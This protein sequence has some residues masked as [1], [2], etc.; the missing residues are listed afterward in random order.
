MTATAAFGTASIEAQLRASLAESPPR[1]RRPRKG[2]GSAFGDPP[3]KVPL[4]TAFR[5]RASRGRGH[6]AKGGSRGVR[7]EIS[8][9]GAVSLPP[10]FSLQPTVGGKFYVLCRGMA[11]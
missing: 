11:A 7:S 6:V 4:G 10:C 2:S 3:S 1:P 8:P 5:I 9:D